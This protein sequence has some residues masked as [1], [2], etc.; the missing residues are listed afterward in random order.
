MPYIIADAVRIASRT[1]TGT[2]IRNLE[3]HRARS[4]RLFAEILDDD[5]DVEEY[6]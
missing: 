2:I 1:N 3:L 5:D 4:G 6:L